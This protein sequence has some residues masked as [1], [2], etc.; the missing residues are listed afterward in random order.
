[1]LAGVVLVLLL[2]LD[3]VHLALE[4]HGVAPLLPPAGDDG[5]EEHVAAEEEVVEYGHERQ[6]AHQ[7]HSRAKV[8]ENG[9]D[10]VQRVEDGQPLHLD[11]DDEEQQHH[12]VRIERGEGEEHRKVDVVRGHAVAY[13]ADEVDY[14][15]VDDLQQ[16][17]AEII[18]GE[19]PRAPLPLQRA[20]DEVVEIERDEQ[21]EGAAVQWQENKGHQPP[22]L[23]AQD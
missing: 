9:V 10:K 19:A 1:A 5:A 21:G 22:Y 6:D 16:H 20:A 7:P 4:V 3:A 12:V 15:A 11:G 13:A 14:E 18:D 17:A 23:P 2:V 8:A